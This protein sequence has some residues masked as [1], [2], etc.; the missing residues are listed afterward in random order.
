MVFV[1][2]ILHREDQPYAICAAAQRDERVLAHVRHVFARLKELAPVARE[3]LCD[4]CL[5][6]RQVDAIS[7]AITLAHPVGPLEIP[8]W[9]QKQRL[10]YEASPCWRKRDGHARDLG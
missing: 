6:R 7:E 2:F 10:L 8:C 1:I 3:E 5:D 9:D 4:G